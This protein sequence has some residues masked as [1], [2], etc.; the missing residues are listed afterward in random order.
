[1]FFVSRILGRGLGSTTSFRCLFGAGCCELAMTPGFA[2]SADTDSVGNSGMIS[3][4][5]IGAAGRR[6]VTSSRSAFVSVSAARPRPST[7]ESRTLSSAV[8]FD[9]VTLAANNPPRPARQI[10]ANQNVLFN[11]DPQTPIENAVN[12]P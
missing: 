3:A 9:D 1:M 10:A 2:R 5:G 6:Y 8:A 11:L 4:D 12:Q 7:V